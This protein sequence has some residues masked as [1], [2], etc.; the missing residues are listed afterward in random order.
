M[1]ERR[2]FDF[3]DSLDSQDLQIEDIVDSNVDSRRMPFFENTNPIG[4]Q[5]DVTWT[6][7]LRPAESHLTGPA[8]DGGSLRKNNFLQDT[9]TNPTGFSLPPVCIQALDKITWL[10]SC[11]NVVP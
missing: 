7:D 4:E 11:S 3:N 10:P 1:A 2:F 6:I 8:E 9:P 5:L